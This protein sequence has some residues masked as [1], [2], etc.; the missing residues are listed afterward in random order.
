VSP[1]KRERPVKP[2]SVT[3][4]TPRH[5]LRRVDGRSHEGKFLKTT[6]DALVA[7]LGGADRVSVA[8]LILIERCALD[9]LRLE[10]LDT[11]AAH[12]Q[13]TEFDARIMHALRNSTRLTLRT[14]GL[15]GAP[16]NGGKTAGQ[17]LDEHTARIAAMGRL[18]PAQ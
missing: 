6:Q 4:L 9:L 10:L 8:Q 17:L 12:G 16:E 18:E 2:D 11:K 1:T 13:L 7:H 5:R 3:P 14:L 15:K